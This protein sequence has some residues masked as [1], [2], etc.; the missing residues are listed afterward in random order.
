MSTPADLIILSDLHLGRGLNPKTGRYF[1]LE[2]FFYDHDFAEFCDY[3]VRDANERS[4][5]IRLILN[6]DVFD[7]L[8]VEADVVPDVTGKTRRFGPTHTPA[9]AAEIVRQI[10]AGHPRFVDGLAKLLEAGHE[11]FF[12]PG[13]HDLETQ[14]EPVRDV[15]RQALF[16]A[17]HSRRGQEVAEHALAKIHFLNWFYFEP[18]RVWVEHGCQYDPE[19]AFR[20]LLRGK[21]YDAETSIHQAEYDLPLGNFFQRYLFNAFGSITFIVPSARANLRYFRW[22]IL[23]E[24]GLLLRV[25]KS[26]IPFLWQF[27]RRVSQ[28][29]PKVQQRMEQVHAEELSALA[30]KSGLGEKLHAI[31]DVKATG[32][33]AGYAVGIILRQIGKVTL[34]SLAIAAL[35][36]GLFSTGFYAISELHLSSGLKGLLS[37]AMQLLL[38]V[39]AA[40]AV[41][42]VVLRL[43]GETKARPFMDAAL[44]I[45]KLLEV[46][47]VCFGHT[48]DEGIYALA[49]PIGENAWYYNPG[50]WIA[51][52]TP[53]VL[54]PRERVQFGFLRVRE[55]KPELLH[56]VPERSRP[57][58]VVLIDTN[59]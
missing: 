7:L 42:Y 9:I 50:T 44:Y 34:A 21:L 15:V 39:L 25:I 49:K 5:P 4:T 58:P 22:L 18:G 47:L 41:F 26:H 55:N 40:S 48:H 19:N 14:W 59:E 46:P 12:L 20:Y 43:P 33:D 52:F 57:M 8:R 51:V 10:L 1:S 2:T 45:A 27:L 23:N 29:S 36:L 16:V 30:E 28:V 54:V 24:P 6:G 17:I 37:A 56:W 13:N 53:D 11:I 35:L 32:A 31:D 38:L 3:L